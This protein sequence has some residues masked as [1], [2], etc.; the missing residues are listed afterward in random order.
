[1]AM[2]V[3]T[4]WQGQCMETSRRT[5]ETDFRTLGVPQVPVV[6]NISNTDPRYRRKNGLGRPAAPLPA[7][8]LVTAKARVAHGGTFVRAVRSPAAAVNF[9]KHSQRVGAFDGS[10]EAIENA[11]P[12]GR[13][14]A[15]AVAAGQRAVLRELLRRQRFPAAVLDRDTR[16]RRAKRGESELDLGFDR[17]PCP[18]H[19]EPVRWLPGAQFAPVDHGAVMP[20]L[21]HPAARAPLQSDVA[22]TFA[23]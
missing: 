1:M 12:A 15:G 8:S 18:G 13:V 16:Q 20:R 21:V 9:L 4:P 7:C 2:E 23:A 17:G 6:R 22:D 3:M 14:G 10:G 11:G 5:Q 19:H